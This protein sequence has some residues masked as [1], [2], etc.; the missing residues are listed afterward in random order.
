MLAKNWTTVQPTCN[1]NLEADMSDG[2]EM[3]RRHRVA[4]TREV[5]VRIQAI[6]GTWSREC[7]MLDV[8]QDGAKLLL[9]ESVESLRLKEFFLVL[10]TTG[11]A[12]RLCELS[13]IN[14]NEMGVQFVE[15]A[16]PKLPGKAASDQGMHE[17]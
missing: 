13:W 10:S 3:R 4:F 7:G 9:K 15:K 17:V 14:G 11:T 16:F 5:P 8:A 12:F 1:R 6:D 2:P